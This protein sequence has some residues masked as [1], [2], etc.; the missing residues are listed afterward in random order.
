MRSRRWLVVGVTLVAVAAILSGCGGREG[1][2]DPSPSPSASGSGDYAEIAQAKGLPQISVDGPTG[3]PITWRL[4]A[5]TRPGD[6]VGVTQRF[7]TLYMHAGTPGAD[8]EPAL[9]T[10]VA[11]NDGWLPQ[12]RSRL[13][14]PDEDGDEPRQGPLWVWLDA[15]DEQG[16]RATVRGCADVAYFRPEGQ[17]SPADP[18][19]QA[20]YTELE[21]GEDVDGRT[22]W[23]VSRFNA[24]PVRESDAFEARCPAWAKHR[25]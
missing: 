14:D 24:G 13:I 7:L 3:S 25:P 11:A 22:V 5:G 1:D 18:A 15:A 4:P 2:D 21:R 12:L 6:P 23:K 20:W 16:D 8:P 19:A 17:S 10:S 9:A